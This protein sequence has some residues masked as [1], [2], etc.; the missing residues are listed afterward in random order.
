MLSALIILAAA[1]FAESKTLAVQIHLDRAGFS[2][3]T[4][5]G[6]WGVKSAS[7]LMEYEA[8]MAKGV[9]PSSDPSP[10]AAYNRY[11]AGKPVP[12]K[13]VEVTQADIDALVAI[14]ESPSERANLQRMGYTSISEMFAER[15]HLSQIALARLNPGVDWSN[16]RPG[17]KLVI[18]DFPSIEEELAAGDRRSPN[19][20]KR[21]LAALVKVSV[22]S[23]MVRAYDAVGRTLALF[24]CSV[25][26]NKQKIPPHGELKVTDYIA[27]P[28][29]TYTPDYTPPG[30]KA[31]RYIW[32]S[33]ENTPVGVAWLGLNLP[34]YGI[35]G[36]PRPESIG[37]TGSHGCFRLANWNAARL[38]ALCAPGTKVLIE[39]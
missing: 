1:T 15:G 36:T 13:T 10:E 38:Y 2:C 11:F 31:Q 7:A 29:F 32:P 18:P 39:E 4:I 19:R 34:G 30:K 37:F 5:D 14:P 17:L 16:V 26:A 21:P 35:H 8:S 28:N 25:A 23:Q 33:G 6:Q 3:N 24:P 12:F 27:W 9:A 20:P 22:S